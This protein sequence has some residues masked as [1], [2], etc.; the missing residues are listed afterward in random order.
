MLDGGHLFLYLIEAIRRKPVPEKIQEGFFK[1]GFIF[2]IGLMV[3]ATV[4]DIISIL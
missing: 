1:V 2:L 3:F 4:N